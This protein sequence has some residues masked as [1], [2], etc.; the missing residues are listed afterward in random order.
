MPREVFFNRPAGV[1]RASPLTFSRRERA[2]GVRATRRTDCVHETFVAPPQGKIMRARCFRDRREAGRALV[3]LLRAYV[4][5]DD[6][7]VLALPRGGV[8]VGYEIAMALRAPLDVFAVRKLGV[9]GREELAMGA[10]AGAGDAVVDRALIEALGLSQKDVARVVDRERA[11]LARR[12]ILYRD[13][14]PYPPI[15]GNVVILVD[16]GLATG[17][18]MYAAIDALRHLRPVRVVAAIPVAPPQ[19]C[20]TLQQYADEIFCYETPDPFVAV[21]EWYEDFDQI[22]DAEVRRLLTDAD[23]RRRTRIE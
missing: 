1:G 14:R 10:L 4:D 17:A 2:V 8:P 6:V 12:Q 15:E 7:V 20:R 22:D 21:S 9:P 5:R 16:D 3:P 13:H 11:E 19:T 23:M 18:S